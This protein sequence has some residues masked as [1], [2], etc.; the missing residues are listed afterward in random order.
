MSDLIGYREAK[1]SDPKG[2]RGTRVS[3]LECLLPLSYHLFKIK[4]NY[5]LRFPAVMIITVFINVKIVS[6]GSAQRFLTSIQYFGIVISK[7]NVITIIM[8]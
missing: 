2:N 6:E 1:L 3:G 5:F 7:L 8:F 4:K